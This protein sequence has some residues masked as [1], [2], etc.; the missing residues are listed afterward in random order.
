MDHLIDRGLM[1]TEDLI[2]DLDRL[3]DGE[4]PDARLKELL[5]ECDN[6]PSQWRTMALAFVESQ[7][8]S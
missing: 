2:R 4:L 5:R 3:V 1:P 6:N 7:V 8:M